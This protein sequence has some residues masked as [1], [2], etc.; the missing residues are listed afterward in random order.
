MS[1]T[2]IVS[3]S[4]TTGFAQVA[5]IISL[6]VFCLIVVWA[7]LRPKASMQAAA[8][9]VLTDGLSDAQNKQKDP[10]HGLG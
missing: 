2:D 5:F 3:G 9:S 7:L 6:V 8:Q 10:S 4:G 1:L